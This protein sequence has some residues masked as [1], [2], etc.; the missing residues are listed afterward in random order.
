M[1]EAKKAEPIPHEE[2]VA[3]AT[4]LF[5]ADARKWRFVCPVCGHVASTQDWLDAGASESAVAFSCVGRYAG[6]KRDAFGLNPGKVKSGELPPADGDG[7]CNYAGGGLF[8]INPVK[9]LHEG[10][11]QAV[12]AFAAPEPTN[13]NGG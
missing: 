8:A 2:W 6:A 3:E 5:G 10:Q 13:P 4:R 12:F 11:V 7:P 9:V 1:S